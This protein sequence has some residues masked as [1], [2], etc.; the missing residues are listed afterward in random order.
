MYR[1]TVPA[2]NQFIGVLNC[3]LCCNCCLV[4]MPSEGS[5][6]LCNQPTYG[7][8]PRVETKTACNYSTSSFLLCMGIAFYVCWVRSL[9]CHFFLLVLILDFDSYTR[10]ILYRGMRECMLL[11]PSDAFLLLYY[12]FLPYVQFCVCVG[13]ASS[14]NMWLWFFSDLN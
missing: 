2:S 8:V 13:C 5:V 6:S 7:Y 14:A 11:L 1:V 9:C 4:H 3:I 12:L 10:R